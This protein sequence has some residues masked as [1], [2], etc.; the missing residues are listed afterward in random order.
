V[1]RMGEC[2]VSGRKKHG[3]MTHNAQ[4][5]VLKSGGWIVRCRCGFRSKPLPAGLFA[6]RLVYEHMRRATT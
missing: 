3:P 1:G 4:A 5:R 6:Q 2:G